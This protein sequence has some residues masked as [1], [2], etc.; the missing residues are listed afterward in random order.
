MPEYS[1]EIR[2]TDGEVKLGDT[3]LPGAFQSCEVRGAV[4]MDEQQ[5]PGRSGASKQP[6]GFEDAEVTLAL[7]L[8]NDEEGAT[9]WQSAE[10]KLDELV[11]LFTGQDDLARPFVYTVSSPSLERWKIRQV[12][13]RELRTFE[14]QRGGFDAELVLTQH[15]PAT[16]KKEARVAEAQVLEAP[17]LGAEEYF[18]AGAQVTGMAGDFGDAGAAAED[19]GARAWEEELTEMVYEGSIGALAGLKTIDKTEEAEEQDITP[20]VDDDDID[21]L[22]MH[23]AP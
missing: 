5:V 3:I 7:K 4:A 6:L 23:G 14:D 18:T 16:L 20:A 17:S 9:P 22:L 11:S 19:A 10:D 2:L 21:D 1:Q 8:V 13:Y 15:K 12:V